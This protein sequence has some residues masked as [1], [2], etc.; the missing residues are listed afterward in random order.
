M[1]EE[2][3]TTQ[4]A[5]ESEPTQEAEPKAPEVDTSA[6]ADQLGVEPGDLD[7]LKNLKDWE[8]D[9]RHESMDK[10]KVQPEPTVELA[11]EPPVIEP[12]AELDPAARAVFERETQRILKSVGID[13]T[14]VQESVAFAEA[15][16]QDVARRRDK[17]IDT[18][19]EAHPEFSDNFGELTKIMESH[20]LMKYTGTDEGVEYALEV[21]SG[22]HKSQH[23]TDLVENEVQK[24]LKEMVDK[25]EEVVGISPKGDLPDTEDNRTFEEVSATEDDEGIY[26]WLKRKEKK[27]G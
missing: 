2:E 25:G 3:N 1:T 12:D 17:A 4:E 11:P 8:R 27:K 22:V 21:A 20:D 5:P 24:R 15:Y 19:A 6:I 7:K 26:A 16:K 23:L 10:A 9:L 18:W 13:P 14:K